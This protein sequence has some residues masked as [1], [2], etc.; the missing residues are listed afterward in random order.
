MSKEKVV[1]TDLKSVISDIQKDYGE[2]IISMGSDELGNLGVIPFGIYSLDKLTGVGGVCRGRITEIHGMDGTFKSTLTQYLIAEE[3]K[4]GGICAL[5][6]AE[7]AFSPEYA[8]SLGVN[9]E[10]LILI[11]PA[12]AE[13]A[14]TVIEKL[15]ESKEI[16]LI[17]LD[18]STSLSPNTELENDFG[19]SNMGVMSRLNGQFF[20]KITAKLGKTK[21]A[22]VIISQLREMLGSYVPMKVVPGGNAIRFY[23]SLRFEI[24]KSAIKEGTDVKGVT[25]KVK[26]VKNKLNT[27]Y[28]ITE[29]ECMY[30][31]GV[32]KL[33]DLINMAI[34]QNLV[35]MKG[36]GWITYKE[37][38]IQGIDAFKNLLQEN[39]DI[40]QEI[41]N[42]IK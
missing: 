12:S 23:A 25:L 1:K 28:L 17:V 4:I 21:T 37:T 6:D 32:D 33:K 40:L 10:K 22:L 29:L 9:I 39:P 34:S 16:S 41:I 38:K 5:I 27:P 8:A 14:F 36:A 26:C 31:F 20:R 24:T 19:S 3:Q 13:E 11:H 35:E 15:V 30:G 18:S 7:Y 2:G 42:N